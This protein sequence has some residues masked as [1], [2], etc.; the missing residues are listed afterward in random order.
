M[1]RVAIK[2]FLESSKSLMGLDKYKIGL[3]DGYTNMSEAFAE[4]E[5]NI[6]SMSLVIGLSTAFRDLK[7]TEQQRSILLHELLHARFSV[8]EKKCNEVTSYF[9]EEYINDLE[10]GMFSLLDLKDGNNKI[11]KE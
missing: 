5:V 8:Y 10:R 4:V 11:N 2:S 9:E 3:L 6:Y 1:D 7:S